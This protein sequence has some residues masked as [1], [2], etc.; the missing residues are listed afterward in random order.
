MHSIIHQWSANIL[1]IPTLL[2]LG[3]NDGIIQNDNHINNNV[4]DDKKHNSNK[5]YGII[6]GS[7]IKGQQK[8]DGIRNFTAGSNNV[9]SVS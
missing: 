6:V 4:N 7:R 8:H 2:T 9:L 1:D 3:Y 5:K